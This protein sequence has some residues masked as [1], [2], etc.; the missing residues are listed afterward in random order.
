[1]A[2]LTGMITDRNTTV[3]RT[4]D[5]AATTNPMTTHNRLA[6]ISN[7]VVVGGFTG[8]HRAVR[9]SW[10]RIAAG[11]TCLGVRRPVGDGHVRD[12]DRLVGGRHQRT[13]RDHAS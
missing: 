10:S 8:Q 11:V 5:A 2:A 4:S 6:S 12:P 7:V 1:M 13:D 9:G 3:S